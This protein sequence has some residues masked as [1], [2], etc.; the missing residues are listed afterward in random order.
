MSENL[1][2]TTRALWKLA[3]ENTRAFARLSSCLSGQWRAQAAPGG[4][5]E[6]Q[7]LGASFTAE[8]LCA[9]EMVAEWY[10]TRLS[11]MLS[12]EQLKELQVCMNKIAADYCQGA[13]EYA[14][15]HVDTPDFFIYSGAQHAR[16]SHRRIPKPRSSE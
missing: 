5:D 16:E 9:V 13:Y 10:M 4:N 1:D 11:R 3:I 14:M 12:S 15:V 8:M 6:W 7:R 2:E